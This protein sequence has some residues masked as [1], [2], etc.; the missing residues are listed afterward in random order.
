M[1][2]WVKFSSSLFISP[3]VY[4]TQKSWEIVNSYLDLVKDGTS[5]SRDG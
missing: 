1:H 2:S 4:A 5:V 3:K